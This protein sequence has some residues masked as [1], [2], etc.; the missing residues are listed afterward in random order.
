M[1]HFFVLLQKKIP[2]H[3]NPTSSWHTTSEELGLHAQILFLDKIFYFGSKSAKNNQIPIPH[4]L[5]KN[6]L[7]EQQIFDPTFQPLT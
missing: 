4:F 3:S 2:I 5:H 7:L 6:I 1:R